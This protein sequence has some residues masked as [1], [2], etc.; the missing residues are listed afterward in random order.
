VTA[1]RVVAN[2]DLKVADTSNGAQRV[3]DPR[4]H[5]RLHSRK[6]GS[7]SCDTLNRRRAGAATFRTRHELGPIAW[8]IAEP[9]I[10]THDR[11]CA[12][13]SRSND[14]RRSG[15]GNCDSNP[16]PT[17]LG[18]PVSG[19]GTCI[20]CGAGEL[21]ERPNHPADKPSAPPTLDLASLEQRL[22]DT[23]AIGV[24]T[25]LS[26][27]N[28]VDDLLNGFRAFYRGESK[29]SLADLRQRFDLLLLKVL[30]LLQDGDPPLAA[31]ISSSRDAIWSILADREKFQRI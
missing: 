17:Y 10:G 27:K 5:S 24:F 19:Q 21:I 1:P 8:R 31:A 12:R 6:T 13:L 28:Q 20:G 16:A 3:S 29:D 9:N 23:R 2:G 18:K 30:T 26:L 22:R 15:C 25:K 4:L 11:S 14:D 7:A